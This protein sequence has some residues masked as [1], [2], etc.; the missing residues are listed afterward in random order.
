M[1]QLCALLRTALAVHFSMI[2]PTMVLLYRM[3]GVSVCG[4][5]SR[6]HLDTARRG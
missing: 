5:C 3:L 2:Y 6:P 4:T 1:L